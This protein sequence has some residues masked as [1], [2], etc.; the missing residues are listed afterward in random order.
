MGDERVNTVGE[1]EEQ[2]PGIP[3]GLWPHHYRHCRTAVDHAKLCPVDLNSANPAPRVGIVVAIGEQVLGWAAKGYGGEILLPEAHPRAFAARANEH[4]EEALLRQL[5]E[6]ELANAV[7]YVTLEPCCIRNSGKPCVDLLLERGIKTIFIGNCDPHPDISANAWRVLLPAGVQIL[8]FAPELRN[9]A[10]RDNAW[11]FDK[12][13]VSTAESG[14]GAFDFTREDRILGQPGRQFRTH[15]SRRGDDTIWAYGD[16]DNVCIAKG[17]RT[18]DDVDD[19]GRWFEDS[20]RAKSVD[21]GEVVIFK[22]SYGYALVL[23]RSVRYGYAG[24]NPKLSFAYQL[25]YGAVTA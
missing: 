24:E 18:F 3:A 12:F 8:D 10:R 13:A 20:D 5:G 14:A 4:A 22:R 1:H 15:W 2:Q 11:F 17:C 9:E 25:R 23:V 21:A 16:R 7:A 6:A 19:P